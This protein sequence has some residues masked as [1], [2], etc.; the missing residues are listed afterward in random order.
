M[1]KKSVSK[2]SLDRVGTSYACVE[3]F[4]CLSAAVIE[5]TCQRSPLNSVR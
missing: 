2:D 1:L 5:G 4:R 3:A